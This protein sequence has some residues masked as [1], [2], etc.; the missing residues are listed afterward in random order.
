[1]TAITPP[2]GVVADFT[3]LSPLDAMVEDLVAA[4]DASY[5]P[6]DKREAFIAWAQANIDHVQRL[7]AL[8]AATMAW[9]L[10]KGREAGHDPD[11]LDQVALQ[12]AQR[13]IAQISRAMKER[14]G[15]PFSPARVAIVA[16]QI[17]KDVAA[18]P[19]PHVDLEGLTKAVDAIEANTAAERDRLRELVDDIADTGLD[20][21]MRRSL[22]IEVCRETRKQWREDRHP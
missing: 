8:V 22:I 10:I 17:A 14:Q 20:D 15:E 9:W 6:T 11:C 16:Y 12:S 13:A 2:R 3:G 19:A 21:E 5:T 1:M 4:W 18:E 7:H